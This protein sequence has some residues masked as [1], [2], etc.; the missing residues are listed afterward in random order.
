MK[1]KLFFYR[2][3]R[4]LTLVELLIVILIIAILISVVYFATGALTSRTEAAT[5]LA[6]RKNISKE[7]FLKTVMAGVPA[8]SEAEA[9]AAYQAITAE[10]YS[11][12]SHICPANGEIEHKFENDFRDLRLTCK[13][14]IE[15]EHEKQETYYENMISVLD[16]VEEIIKD[17]NLS[18]KEKIDKIN[19]LLGNTY[20]KAY[21]NNSYFRDALLEKMGGLWPAV[22]D[23]DKALS[24]A[25]KS[26]TGKD[27]FFYQPYLIS[28]SGEYLEWINTSETT[29]D[30]WNAT[31]IKYNGKWYSTVNKYTGKL[32]TTQIAGIYTQASLDDVYKYLGIIDSN[33]NLSSN[34]VE[35]K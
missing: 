10:H 20:D 4:A 11:G 35:I 25:L 26:L 3:K 7:F 16:K 33:G 14:H 18:T 2:K 34:W 28:E 9:E 6:N 5:C 21:L 19:E 29:H 13:L 27:S 12:N 30:S 1:D 23:Q 8:K 15:K 24:D 17:P 22:K 31:A 32:N